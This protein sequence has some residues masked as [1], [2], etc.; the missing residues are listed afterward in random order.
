A[1]RAP[2]WRWRH[3]ALPLALTASFPARCGV[4]ATLAAMEASGE[5]AVVVR[6][7]RARDTE[8]VLAL[9]E[10]ARS[11]A[12]STPDDQSGVARLIEHADDALLVAEHQGRVVGVLVAAWD[13]WRGN[14]YRLAVVPEYRRQGIARQLVHAGQERLL[15]K[16]AGR[17]T[18]L[19]A[20]DEADATGLWR[21]VGYDRDEY[22]VRFVKNL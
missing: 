13:G 3:A 6:V 12:A 1:D 10:R 15:A 8:D 11:P 2:R 4:R 20:H 18:A 22:I 19:V 16:G 21:A 9:W 7:A 5:A 14:M 17:V